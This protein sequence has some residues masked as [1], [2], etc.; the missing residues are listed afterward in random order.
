MDI[1]EGSIRPSPRE[2]GSTR[3]SSFL[4]YALISGTIGLFLL[5][6]N[7]VQAWDSAE[8]PV[9]G[10]YAI[11][12]LGNDGFGYMSNALQATDQN[13]YSLQYWFE[14][15]EHDAD[16][17]Y[18]SRSHYYDPVSERGL[19]GFS[20]ALQECMGSYSYAIVHW[21]T[22]DIAHAA[23]QLGHAAHLVQDMAIP[24]H[25]H[26]DPLNGHSV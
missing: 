7:G 26:L 22:G 3:R 8:H 1:T 20:S 14:Q 4:F 17:A 21:K 15:G 24:F 5:L 9:L 25:T 2:R 18:Q 23:F 6:P 13:G 11:A 10:D 16:I 19:W 12:T